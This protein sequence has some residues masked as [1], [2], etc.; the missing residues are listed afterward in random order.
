VCAMLKGMLTVAKLLGMYDVKGAVYDGH[1][2]SMMLKG[3]LYDV[4]GLI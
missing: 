4:P 3:V 1:G 2:V